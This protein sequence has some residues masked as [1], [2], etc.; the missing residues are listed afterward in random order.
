MTVEPFDQSEVKTTPLGGRPS[1][2]SVEDFATLAAPGAG[3]ADLLASLPGFLAANDLRDLVAAIA[4]ARTGGHGVVFGLGGHV[5]KTG[6]SPVLIDLM[7]RGVVTALAMPGSTAI[8]DFE[9]AA[10]GRTSEEVAARLGTGEFGTTEETGAFFAAAT[11]EGAT[12]AGLGRALGRRI[13]D[14]NL[15]HARASLLAAAARLDLPATVHVAIG[16]DTVHVHPDADGAAIGAASHLDF[17]ILTTVVAALDHGVFV[18][19][20]SAV[21]LPEVFLKA[22]TI[23]RNTGRPIDGLFTANLDMLRHY[24]P[25]RNVVRRPPDRGVDLAGHHEILLPLLRLAILETMHPDSSGR[26]AT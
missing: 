12:G 4:T 2:V 21:L 1:L 6:C 20:G 18:N 26:E 16:T 23:A 10:V 7:E 19:V 25:L 24:R 9:I 11:A 8:H 22:V 3:I 15:P 13:L 5:V 14:A 17:R